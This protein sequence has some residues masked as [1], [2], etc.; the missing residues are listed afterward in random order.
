MLTTIFR[1]LPKKPVVTK[2]FGTYDVNRFHF[3][4]IIAG[5]MFEGEELVIDPDTAKKPIS[6][7]IEDVIFD[8][9][10]KSSFEIDPDWVGEEL[11]ESP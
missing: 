8:D 9:A 5:Y 11:P 4:R 7:P 10:P 2:R 1:I 6:I 3:P